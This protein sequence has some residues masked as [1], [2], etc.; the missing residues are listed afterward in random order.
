MAG[1]VGSEAQWGPFE[2]AWKSQLREPLPGKP[3]LTKFHMTDCVNQVREFSGYSDPEVDL[4][5][6]KFRD[7]ILDAGV[8]GYS[9]GVPRQEW[10]KFITGARRF[11]FGTPEGH[12]TRYCIS[13]V[14]EWAVE[15]S[16]DRQITVILRL[17]PLSQVDQYLGLA[18]RIRNGARFGFFGRS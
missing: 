15:N 7:I 6:K 11:F 10:D 16:P 3:P 18:G 17:I 4:V 1:V 12:C 8:H 13:F 2:D 5:I 9:I 14:A